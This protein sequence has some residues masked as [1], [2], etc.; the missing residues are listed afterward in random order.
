[1]CLHCTFWFHRF[2]RVH[3]QYTSTLVVLDTQCKRFTPLSFKMFFFAPVESVAIYSISSDHLYFLCELTVSVSSP[4]PLF[5]QHVAE[6]IIRPSTRLRSCSP[7]VCA[8]FCCCLL[9]SA[10]ADSQ[11]TPSHVSAYALLIRK[12]PLRLICCSTSMHFS[13]Q[14]WLKQKFRP[15][16]LLDSL[17]TTVRLWSDQ[18]GKNQTENLTSY[19]TSPSNTQ[20]NF[21]DR[22]SPL[23]YCAGFP[24][25][26]QICNYYAPFTTLVVIFKTPTVLF[27]I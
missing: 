20:S 11:T 1:M 26:F 6:V 15:Q 12:Q 8:Y 10:S 22:K 18:S 23:L 2:T 27:L 21:F 14:D 25:N 19:Q 16:C 13:R 3:I 24:E 5:F 17:K 7:S 9:H 4:L